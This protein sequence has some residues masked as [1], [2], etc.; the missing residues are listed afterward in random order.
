VA[1]T[2]AQLETF[3]ARPWAR[4]RALK[5]RHHAVVVAAEGA[6]AAF[7]VAAQLR[8]HA[9]AMGADDTPAAR[10]EDLAAA[11]RLRKLLD[12][13]SRRTRRAR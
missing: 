8:A 13:V 7:R 5:D 2:R 12:R 4:L 1:P 9:Q 10:R 11:V 6:D 3:L